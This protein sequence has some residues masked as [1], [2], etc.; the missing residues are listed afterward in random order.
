MI[1][2]MKQW[3][4]YGFLF[5][6]GGSFYITLEVLYRGYSHWSMS[7]L[8]GLVFIA[9]GLLNRVWSW[10]IDLILQILVGTVI[11]TIGEFVTGCIV[12]LWLGW[13]IWDYSNLSY[14]LL[15]QICPQ[16]I[17]LWIPIVVVA[18]IL[19]DIIRW[20]FFNEEKPHYY[21]W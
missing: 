1:N 4:K 13:S 11:A 6:F 8:A 12:N 5:W 18:I 3:L 17:A 7:V 9:I 10:E 19:D 20:K 2:L 15:G 16:F 14:N 21:W